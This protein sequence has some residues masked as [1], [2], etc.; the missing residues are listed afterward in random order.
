MAASEKSLRKVFEDFAG[1][2]RFN[3]N[4]DK[5]WLSCAEAHL[6]LK[7]SED[8]VIGCKD[9]LKLLPLEK[10]NILITTALWNQFL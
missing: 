4:D 1:T 10:T 9:S 7:E 3:E 2:F 6:E 8:C 5:A